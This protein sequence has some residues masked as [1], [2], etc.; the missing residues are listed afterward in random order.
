VLQIA[1]RVLLRVR[2]LFDAGY[3]TEQIFAM[4]E[5]NSE[6]MPTFDVVE[7][8]PLLDSACFGPED[9]SHIAADIGHAYHQYEV[10]LVLH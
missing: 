10:R 5:L 6:Q 7:Y 2:S 8:A 1:L 9:W 4:D 3:F